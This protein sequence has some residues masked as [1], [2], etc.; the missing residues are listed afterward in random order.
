MNVDELIAGPDPLSSPGQPSWTGIESGVAFARTLHQIDAS[1]RSEHTRHR[2]Y[3]TVTT[4]AAVLTAAIATS[5]VLVPGLQS[6]ASSFI[7]LS[8]TPPSARFSLEG[9]SCV[10][11]TTCMAVGSS[12][13]TSERSPL[14]ELWN[15][16][17]WVI[18]IGSAPAPGVRASLQGV[19]CS[20]ASSCA[21]VGSSSVPGSSR[22]TMVAYV[23]NGGRWIVTPLPSPGG[24]TQT[25]LSAVSC[26]SPS[27][28]LAVGSFVSAHQRQTLVEMWNGSA[29][30]LLR[31]PNA[32]ASA[33]RRCLG[34]RLSASNLSGVSCAST[35]SCVAVGFSQDSSTFGPAPLRQKVTSLIESWN[36]RRWRIQ[37]SPNVP[38]LAPR[39]VTELSGVSCA[40]ADSCAA[41]GWSTT[42]LALSLHAFTVI[43]D[44]RNWVLHVPP[45]EPAWRGHASPVDMLDGVSCTSTSRC[46]AVG[47]A[48]GPGA[49]GLTSEVWSGTTWTVHR[50]PN[51]HGAIS[52]EASG[53]SCTTASQCMAVG[54]SGGS[55]TNLS[56][57]SEQW[58]GTQWTVRPTP[59]P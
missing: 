57:L 17:K 35:N 46:T 40:S 55:G 29:W 48:E 42:G 1:A 47:F 51:L 11:P 5:I 15:G 27:R 39:P 33:S 38:G 25:A 9:V 50:L 44:G 56:T 53:I 13:T 37:P 2:S 59:V 7:G 4:V 8:S 16:R 3:R 18:Q 28:C 21:A 54:S 45:N 19:S 49:N 10:T 34:C 14:A 23:W 20:T 30:G 43:W 36:G 32:T 58:T 31:S 26:T 22:Q 52:G 24:A 6:K 41:V 12:G